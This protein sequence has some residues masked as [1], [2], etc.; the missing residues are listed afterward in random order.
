MRIIFMIG[1]LVVSAVIRTPHQGGTFKSSRT[2]QKREQL[3]RPFRL[4]RQMRKQAVVAQSNAYTGRRNQSHEKTNLKEVQPVMPDVNGDTDNCG[5]KRSDEKCNI[6][7]INVFPGQ[8]HE[9]RL[10]F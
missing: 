3:H 7:P 6:P 1:K 8:V 9:W 5:E 10:W 4:K 2:K